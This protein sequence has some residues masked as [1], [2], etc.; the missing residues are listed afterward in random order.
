MATV[1]SLADVHEAIHRGRQIIDI[2]W[3]PALSAECDCWIDVARHWEPTLGISL[4]LGELATTE[5]DSDTPLLPRT[6]RWTRFGLAGCGTRSDWCHDWV[7]R[8]LEVERHNGRRFDWLAT[9]Y[10][11]HTAC[12]APTPQQV[13]EAAVRTQCAGLLLDVAPD[14]SSSGGTTLCDCLSPIALCDLVRQSREQQLPLFI[15]GGV[16]RDDLEWLADL[17]PDVVLFSE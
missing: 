5:V 1:A 12:H 8:R 13:L 17:D 7:L 3:Q 15:G 11:N 16:T 10:A 6:V 2:A 9:A 14:A 4:S